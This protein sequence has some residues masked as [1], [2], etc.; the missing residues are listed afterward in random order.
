MATEKLQKVLARAGIGSRRKIE[1]WIASGSVSVNGK[2]ARLG[3]RVCGDETIHVD[4]K[5]I[6]TQAQAVA[7]VKI[8]L[9]HKPEGE[10][11]SQVDPR[12][13]ST[14]FDRLPQLK[15]GRWIVVG[16]LDIN[17]SGLLLFTNNGELAHRLMHPSYAIE[18]EYAVRV[19]G[20]VDKAIL[21]RLR[22]GVQLDDG[23]ARFNTINAIGGTGVNH[24]YQV[25]LQEGRNREVR[26]LWGSQNLIVSRLVRTRFANISLPRDLRRG[27]FV[28]LDSEAIKILQRMVILK[29]S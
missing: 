14:V 4:G 12:E 10:I 25:V 5:A 7:K 22:K 2:V 9:Y 27:Q 11:C 8:L 18:R 17:T 1:K 20:N 24:W 16:R 21:Q 3:T 15:Q 19:K 13:R 23:M 26:R 29:S 28:Y 6:S